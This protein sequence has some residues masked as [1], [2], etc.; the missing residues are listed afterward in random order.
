VL[1]FVFLGLAT[2]KLALAKGDENRAAKE[3]LKQIIRVQKELDKVVGI[4]NILAERYKANKE[5]ESKIITKLVPWGHDVMLEKRNI[6]TVVVHSSY[7][8]LGM[9]PYDVDG[10]MYEYLLY[11]VGPHYLISGTGEVYRMMNDNDLAW[12]AGV[13]QMPDGRK[14]VNK[15]SIGVE[16]IQTDK[17]EANYLEYKALVDLINYLQSKYNIKYII[18]HS[19]IAP[20]GKKTDP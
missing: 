11:D 16:L 10:V 2:D 6:D 15:F 18:G 9:N 3:E 5:F 8:A 12:H 7:D 1:V 20:K 13:S 14:S 4:V 19:D 17:E